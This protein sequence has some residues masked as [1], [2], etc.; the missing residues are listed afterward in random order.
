MSS[1]TKKFLITVILA[2]VSS[3]AF[4]YKVTSEKDSTDLRNNKRTN[5]Q[6]MCD[7]GKSKL[8]VK[9]HGM[10]GAWVYTP[11]DMGGDYKTL[12]EAAKKTC[13]E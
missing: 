8:V 7:N 10:F 13:K 1:I 2:S 3:A 6:V 9:Q 12:D 4:A 11:S 5:I